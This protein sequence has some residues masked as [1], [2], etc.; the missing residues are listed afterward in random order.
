MMI[1]FSVASA[2]S[3]Q[4]VRTSRC[5]VTLVNCPAQHS[6]AM[7]TDSVAGILHQAALNTN[8][9]VDREPHV[10][11]FYKN[12]LQTIIQIK[13]SRTLRTFYHTLLGFDNAWTERA[14]NIA[15]LLVFYHKFKTLHSSI[16]SDR[17]SQNKTC[18]A[19]GGILLQMPIRFHNHIAAPWHDSILQTIVWAG[20]RGIG[21]SSK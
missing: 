14:F 11:S 7:F 17:F 19:T 21:M 8:C 6:A 20:I 5:A 1:S 2:S 4:H 9:P 18:P 13:N 3:A 15:W 10:R 12:T 16:F